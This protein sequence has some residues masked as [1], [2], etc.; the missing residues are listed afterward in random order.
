MCD[1]TIIPEAIDLVLRTEVYGK[2]GEIFVLD[3]EI[4]LN[5]VK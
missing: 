2:D 5:H 1:F 4:I 3:K